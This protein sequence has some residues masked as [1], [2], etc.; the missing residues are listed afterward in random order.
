MTLHQ[1]D[2]FNVVEGQN[3]GVKVAD[4][5]MIKCTVTGKILAKSNYNR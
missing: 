4:G 2:L 1:A 3:L 5:H